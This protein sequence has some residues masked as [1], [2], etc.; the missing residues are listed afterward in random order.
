MLE[1]LEDGP[2]GDDI[3]ELLGC[4]TKKSL[5]DN[6]DLFGRNEF[7]S[8]TTAWASFTAFDRYEGSN[9]MAVGGYSVG[10]YTA[11]AIAGVWDRS[12]TL[13]LIHQRALLMNEAL[14][15]A[16]TT[17][18]MLAVI[19]LPLEKVQSMLGDHEGISIS[20]INAP[21]Q[22]TLAGPVEALEALEEA[23]RSLKPRKIQRVATAGAW[24][25]PWM[26]PVVERLEVLLL[27]SKP[28]SP[29]L[30]LLSNLHGGWINPDPTVLCRE[31]ALQVSRP[32]LWEANVRHLIA[33]GAEHLV[34]I[35]HGSVLSR[36]GFFIDRSVKHEAI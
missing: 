22:L 14:D 9:P 26:D 1:A 32:V 2:I 30:P 18:G 3:D 36:F 8:L 7:A 29:Q 34:E 12:T 11:A 25:S 24:H 23:M 27:N 10:Q 6:P 5:R 31:M 33:S 28:S 16:G 13:R 17:T 15:T 4:S 35:G 19:G 20:N 21:G